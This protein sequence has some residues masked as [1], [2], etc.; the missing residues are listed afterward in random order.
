M[1][2]LLLSFGVFF[3]EKKNHTDGDTDKDSLD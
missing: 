1:Q 3:E 2:D